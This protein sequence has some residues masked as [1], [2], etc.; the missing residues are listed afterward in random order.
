[1]RR[2]SKERKGIITVLVAFALVAVIG[3]AA[4]ALDGG[5]LTDQY[6]QVQTAA[7]AT[8]L[9]AAVDLYNQSL[10]GGGGLDTAGT[11]RTSALRNASANGYSND[12]TNSTVTINI[13]PTSGNYSGK[14]GYAEV[15]IQYNQPRAF[16]N[17]FGSGNVPVKA[18]A[19][20]CGKAGGVGILI[21]DNYLTVAAQIC[22]KINILNDGVIYCNSNSTVK[23]G[24][25]GGYGMAGGVYL[26]ST[27]NVSCGGVSVVGSMTKEG[28]AAIAYTN[29]GSYKTG[30]DVVGDPL[31]SVPEPVPGTSQ[32]NKSYNT[33]TTMSPG[34]YDTITVKKG[35]NLT[36]QPGVYCIDG[37]LEVQD[38]ATLTG[39][40]VMI[41]NTSGD[42]IKFDNADSVYL[43]PPTSGTYQGI[44]IFEPRSE[45]KE[46]HIKCANSLTIAGTLYAQQGE[47]DLRPNGASTTMTC[48]SYICAQAEWCQGYSSSAS[49]GT[50]V[51]NP[52]AAVPGDRPKIVE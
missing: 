46:V 10:K 14:S 51:I 20:A 34:S 2:D 32:G 33:T 15:I 1:M 38:G 50:I 49:N 22:G 7:D 12:G 24:E 11:A 6:R 26:E 45:T 42:N 44:S 48:G 35:G 16:S 25:F 21:L 4:L 37:G 36:M 27:A 13:P 39:T 9:A 40:G 28:G 43:T 31:A 41:Y 17:I 30:V 23:N 5:M 52:S 3:F 47:F 29:G 8:A 19:V 18:R